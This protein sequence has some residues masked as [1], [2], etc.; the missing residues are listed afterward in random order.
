M[1]FVDDDDDDDDDS[2][3][4]TVQ[5]VRTAARIQRYLGRPTY[6]LTNIGGVKL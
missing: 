1:K 6:I 4:M 2:A 5:V 3:S